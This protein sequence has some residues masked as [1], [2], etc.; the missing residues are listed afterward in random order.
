[1]HFVYP[2]KF[3][4]SIVFNFS[5][6]LQSSQGKLKTMLMQNVWGQKKS[7]MDNV[8]LVNRQLSFTH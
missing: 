5:W 6:D 8:E 2:Q 1:M 3:C 7:I 4:I